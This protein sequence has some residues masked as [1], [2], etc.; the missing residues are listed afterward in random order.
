[1]LMNGSK[2]SG[3]TLGLI[4]GGLAISSS[5]C[6]GEKPPPQDASNARSGDRIIAETKVES[7]RDDKE[8]TVQLSEEFRRE[9]RLPNAPQG[10]PKFDFDKATLHARGQN[11]LDDVA[12]CLSQG[13]LKDRTITIIG[14]TDA[15]GSEAHNKELAATR[16]EAARSYL[17]QRGVPVAQVRLISRGELG[18]RGSDEDTWALDRRVDLELG[19]LS[20]S[21]STASGAA[22]QTADTSSSPILEGTRMQALP[23]KTKVEPKGSSYSDQAEGGSVTGSSGPGSASGK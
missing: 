3:I 21:A 14:R 10:A 1:M 22:A 4:L 11:I 7:T 18:A 6:S 20:G 9:C 2:R 13:P 5:A 15:R 16:A 23:T 17:V 12:T 19:D 8:T